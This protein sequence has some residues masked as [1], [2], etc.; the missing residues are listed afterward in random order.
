MSEFYIEKCKMLIFQLNHS[1]PA[2]SGH[3]VKSTWMDYNYKFIHV[4]KKGVLDFQ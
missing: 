2:A 3:D 4:P 1:Q